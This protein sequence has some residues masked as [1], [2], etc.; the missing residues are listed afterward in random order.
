MWVQSG[1]DWGNVKYEEILETD[2]VEL[3]GKSHEWLTRDQVIEIYKSD[4]VG[5]SVCDSKMG[6][7]KT[8]RPHPEVPWLEDARQYHVHP[9][10]HIN[11]H[12]LC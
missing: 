1:G 3:S 10:T 5:N 11:Y 7:T 9:C 2:D 6:N 8:S 12:C 4:A